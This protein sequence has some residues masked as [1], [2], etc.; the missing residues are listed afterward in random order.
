M[1]LPIREDTDTFEAVM[2]LPVRVDRKVL[3]TDRVERVALVARIVLVVKVENRVD[4]GLIVLIEK[5]LPIRDDAVWDVTYM[6]DPFMVEKNVLAVVAF[7]IE[8]VDV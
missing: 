8:T 5:L 1:V 4:A 3:V 7:V 6:V 2:V